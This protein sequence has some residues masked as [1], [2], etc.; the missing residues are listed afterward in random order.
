MLLIVRRLGGRIYHC[1]RRQYQWHLSGVRYAGIRGVPADFP[2]SVHRHRTPL[3]RD[4]PG[5]EM[6]LQYNKIANL[7]LAVPRLSGIILRPGETLSFWRLVGSPSRRKGYKPGMVLRN[8]RIEPGTGGGLCQLTNL[9]YWL[10]LHTPLTVT[11][12]WRHSYDVFPDVERTVPFGSGATCAYPALD[13]QIRND[14]ADSYLLR[15]ELDQTHLAGEWLA[16]GAPPYRYEV[17]QAAHHFEHR[18]GVGYLRHNILRR[19]VF[20]AA[21]AQVGDELVAVNKALMMYR[22][23]L[24]EKICEK[25]ADPCASRSGRS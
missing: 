4:L 22:P 20:D 25:V 24:P 15:L 3:L 6:R 11:E 8:G 18:P 23:F 19:R 17:Y 14:T 7:E 12:R 16:T 9:L 1:L 21:G 10:T 13:L 5:L 2:F